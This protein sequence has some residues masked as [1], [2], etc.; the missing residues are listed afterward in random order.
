MPPAWRWLLAMA[1]ACVL[2]R[3][4]CDQA[5][6][7]ITTLSGQR[8]CPQRLDHNNPCGGHL[9]CE[10]CRANGCAWCIAA[11]L[12]VEDKPWKCT[13]ED[14]HIGNVGKVKS[15]QSPKCWVKMPTG[16]DQPLSETQTPLE[17]FMDQSGTT[18]PARC[19]SRKG[20]YDKWCRRDDAQLEWRSKSK[21]A[22]VGALSMQDTWYQERDLAPPPQRVRRTSEVE[23]GTQRMG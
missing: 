11:R 9:S 23:N 12:C 1:A 15:C 10:D 17:W 2:G 21:G 22:P 18:D 16:C 3:S 13:G 7:C 8:I 6:E 19:A 5:D 20:V 4:L 14:D